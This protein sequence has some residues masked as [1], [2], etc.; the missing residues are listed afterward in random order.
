MK[1]TVQYWRIIQPDGQSLAGRFPVEQV[2]KRLLQAQKDGLDRH[3][4]C[5]DG[6]ILIAHGVA[7]PRHRMLILDKVRRDNLPSVGDPAGTRRAIGLASEEGLLEPTYCAFTKHNV[8]AMLT[9]GDG[10]RPRRLVDYLRSKLDINVGIEPVLTQNLDQVLSEMR[11]SAIEVAIPAN[12]INRDLVGGDWVQ[13]LAGAQVLTHDGVVRLGVSVGK[14]GNR[15]HKEGIRRHLR[16]LIDRLRGSGALSEFDSAKVSG[17]IAGTQ[18]SVDLLEDR[19]VE[20]ADVDADRL[21]DPQRS[22]EY[23]RELLRA[24]IRRNG[25][26][27]WSVVPEVGQD[28]VAFP[29]T[30]IEK[31]ADEKS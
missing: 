27:L 5:R 6:M 20:K 10:P 7:E 12:R 17:S 25:D 21:N 4:Q 19:F 9:S 18:R 22:T 8:I 28:H 23:A 11:V 15:A 2:V 24:S 29:D 1:R 30:F 3:R 16:E 13:A 14:R 31:P 26:Y